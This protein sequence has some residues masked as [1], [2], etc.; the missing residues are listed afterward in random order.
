MSTELH[1]LSAAELSKALASLP[2]WSVA[3]GSAGKQELHKRFTFPGFAPAVG[4]M[5]SAMEPIDRLNHHPRWENV[6]NRVDVFLSSHD[7]GDK[8]STLDVE[9]AHLLERLDA[10]ANQPS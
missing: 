5:A 8:I 7:I 4:F 9:L 1:P 3:K 2:G 10:A 6:W